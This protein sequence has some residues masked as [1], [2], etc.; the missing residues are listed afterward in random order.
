MRKADLITKISDKTGIAKVDV[1][2]TLE[3]FFKEI[4]ESLKQGENIY[5]RGFGSFIVKKRR[6]KIGRNIKKN[7]AIIIPEHFIP[8]FKP[9]KTFM[10][11]VKSAVPAKK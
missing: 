11:K 6:Q 4:K 7:E 8:A 2:V 10:D 5:V 3:S 1:L 9:A